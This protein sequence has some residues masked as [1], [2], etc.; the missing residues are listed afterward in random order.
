VK[1]RAIIPVK[2]LREGKGRLS[3]VLDESRRYALNVELLDHTLAVASA[4][5]GAAQT[6]VVSPDPDVLARAEAAGV[7]T[8]R[9]T[10]GELNGALDL[11]ARHAA[12]GG[13]DGVL[14][15]PVDLPRATPGDLLTLVSNRSGVAIVSDRRGVGTNALFVAPPTALKFRFGEN[16]FLAHLAAAREAGFS[17]EID[18]IPNLSFDIDTPEDFREWRTQDV[19]TIAGGG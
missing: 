4:F 7:Q 2:S 11:A 9:D 8:L 16:S 17:V 3:A 10:V 6:I 1:L 14:I 13:A 5:P 19:A 12:D 15:V 18:T